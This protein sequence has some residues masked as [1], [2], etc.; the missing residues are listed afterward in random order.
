MFNGTEILI[1]R[2]KFVKGKLFIDK[3]LKPLSFTDGTQ[4][5]TS[6]CSHVL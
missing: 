6:K 3:K 5:P 2:S 4:E 1:K